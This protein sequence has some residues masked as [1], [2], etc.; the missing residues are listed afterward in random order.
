MCTSHSRWAMVAAGAWE[1]FLWK[2]QPW[3]VLGRTFFFFV[4][5]TA[6]NPFLIC[7]DNRMWPCSKHL[8]LNVDEITLEKVMQEAWTMFHECT[9]NS[10][11][12]PLHYDIKCSMGKW[13]A[14]H[15]L[16]RLQE[17]KTAFRM[18]VQIK[19]SLHV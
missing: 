15:F 2:Q 10:L 8:V 3:V 4:W 19:L 7:S 11:C 16:Q 14:T 1:V 6:G 12:C 9:E 18:S 17:N 13:L 5:F